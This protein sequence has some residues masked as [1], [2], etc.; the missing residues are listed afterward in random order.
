MVGDK[1]D[2]QYNVDQ[3]ARTLGR[4]AGTLLAAVDEAMKQVGANSDQIDA[5]IEEEEKRRREQSKHLESEHERR[6]EQLQRRWK[7]Y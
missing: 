6:R 3:V 5:F 1:Q 4:V 7:R 2:T